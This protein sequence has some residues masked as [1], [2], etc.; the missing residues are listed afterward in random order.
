VTPRT[1]PP[2]PPPPRLP[3]PASRPRAARHALALLP[4]RIRHG[5]PG[6]LALRTASA[7]A[8]AETA[9]HA[10]PGPGPAAGALAGIATC[11][12]L[13]ARAD[14]APPPEQSP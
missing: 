13:T 2:P 1:I 10:G 11:Y 5:R 12:L 8:A 4:A 9:L 7:L 3:G 14:L 6:T